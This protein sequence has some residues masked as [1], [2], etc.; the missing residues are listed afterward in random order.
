LFDGTSKKNREY[1]SID[2]NESRIF[3]YNSCRGLEGWT[4]VCLDVDMLVDEK[5][6]SMVFPPLRY[7]ETEFDR[8][9]RIWKQVCLWVLMPL[10]R[11][12]DTLV[13]SLRNPN[14]KVGQLFYELSRKLDFVE[15][16]YPN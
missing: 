13:I 8:Q 10:T 14:S 6:R 7:G 9:V 4:V 15:W 3:N 1:Y 12:I 11:A 16:R 2:V 5:L